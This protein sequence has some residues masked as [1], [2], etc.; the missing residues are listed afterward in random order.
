MACEQRVGRRDVHVIQE[1]MVVW[2]KGGRMLGMFIFNLNA[3]Y[4]LSWGHPLQTIQVSHMFF[5]C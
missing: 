2:Y 1:Y 4:I 3:E 5:I